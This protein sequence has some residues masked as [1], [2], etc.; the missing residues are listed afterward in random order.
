MIESP[1]LSMQPDS[2]DASSRVEESTRT[3]VAR[4]L[5]EMVAMMLAHPWLLV[6]TVLPN[7]VSQSVAPAQ[8]WLAHEVL[9]EVA[10]GSRSFSLGDLLGYA[11][12]AIAI[13]LGLGLLTIFEKVF[14]RMYDDRLLIDTQRRWFEIRGA[15]C[16]GEHVAK[17]TNDCK[18]LGKLFDL[19]Q[20]EI[21]VV[22]IGIP[23]VLIWQVNLSPQLLPALVVT[24]FIPFVISLVFGQIIQRLSHH[25]VVLVAQVSSAVAQG[26]KQRL[27]AEQEKL[28][29]NRVRFEIT[30][31]FSEVISEF[32]FWVSLVLVLVLAWSGVWK[33]LPDQLSAAE[34]G[35]FLVNLKLLS[36]PLNAFTK[37][38]NKIREAWPSVR[39]VM[40]PNEPA[41]QEVAT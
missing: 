2:P 26:D 31:Q 15:G 41:I 33:L 23:A 13:F 8:A 18:N 22:L 19:A 35:V 4:L 28:Y 32:A 38:H 40:R 24:A 20:K 21:W 14:N 7:V 36:K 37:M 39:R 29:R 16:A 10:K 34:I 6:L 17:A 3:P 9:A 30:K 27:H 12:Y 25:G 5:R 11:P 1:A